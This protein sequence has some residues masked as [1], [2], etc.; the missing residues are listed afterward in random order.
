MRRFSGLLLRLSLAFAFLYPPIA[1]WS[2]PFT[3]LGY[4]PHFVTQL[5]P[6]SNLVLLHTFGVVEIVLALWLVWGRRAHI[7]AAVMCFLLLFIVV[8]NLDQLDVLFRDIAL[9]GL[10]LALA[11][12]YW[13]RQRVV[14]EEEIVSVQ[15]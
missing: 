5:W 12:M 13:P 2:D 1:A 8:T 6:L 14:V 15:Y 3:W 10:A 9:A 11:L 7:P 4:I